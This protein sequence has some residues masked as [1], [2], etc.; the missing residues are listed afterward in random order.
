M[1]KKRMKIDGNYYPSDDGSPQN[2]DSDDVA[3]EKRAE[4]EQKKAVERRKS[5]ALR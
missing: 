1:A 3:E 4:T 5:N 2:A